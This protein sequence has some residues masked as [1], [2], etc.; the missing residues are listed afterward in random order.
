[1]ADSASEEDQY[2]QD[3]EEEEKGTDPEL[4]KNISLVAKYICIRVENPNMGQVYYR[5]TKPFL[6]DGYKSC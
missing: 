6:T 5:K 1:M 3:E 2:P 4:L